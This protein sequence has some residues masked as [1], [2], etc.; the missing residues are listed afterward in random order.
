MSCR[1]WVPSYWTTDCFWPYWSVSSN[2]R[3]GKS[4]WALFVKHPS[5]L[6][7]TDC[8]D[9]AAMWRFLLVPPAVGSVGGC[10]DCSTGRNLRDCSW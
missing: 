9:V 5:A 10:L 6:P 8:A 4:V 1:H 3:G 2:R 7:V